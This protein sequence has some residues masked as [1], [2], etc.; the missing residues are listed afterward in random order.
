MT[1]RIGSSQASPIGAVPRMLPDALGLVRLVISGPSAAAHALE[2][3][4]QAH[5]LGYHW[6]STIRLPEG[7]RDPVGYALAIAAGLGVAA[8]IAP[9]VA[10]VDDQ[11][12]RISADFDF[13]TVTPPRVWRRGALKPVAVQ[14]L[15]LNDCTWEPV[16][17][18]RDCARLLWESH[19]DCFPD[20]LARLAASAALSALDEVD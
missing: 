4:C 1:N 20:C 17:L 11:P 8:I 16:Q 14:A 15:L 10:H 9:D 2:I 6:L 13:A 18:E 12:E 7:I 3:Q 19:R 5:H